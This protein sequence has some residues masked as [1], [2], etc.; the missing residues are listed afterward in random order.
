MRGL[1]LRGGPTWSAGRGGTPRGGTA[2][3][4]IGGQRPLHGVRSGWSGATVGARRS[5]RRALRVGGNVVE[6]LLL[7]VLL[8]VLLAALAVQFLWSGFTYGPLARRAL[9]LVSLPAGAVWA[10]VAALSP[11]RALVLRV[12][13]GLAAGAAAFLALAVAVVLR[14]RER[15]LAALVG[16]LAGL[17]RHVVEQRREVERLFWQLDGAARARASGPPPPQ[18]PVEGSE[19]AMAVRAWQ[20]GAGPREARVRAARIAE[21]RHEFR[22]CSRDDLAARARVLEAAR[23]DAPPEQRAIL[24]ARLALLWQVFEERL[25]KI[26]ADGDGPEVR[27][28]W[29]RARRELARLQEE[30]S[31]M[32]RQ[33][34]A[35]AQRRLPL[36]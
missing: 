2:C 5:F 29:E 11:W 25:P 21:W 15:K 6:Y 3:A 4:D 33:R 12:A 24:E 8:L 23:D 20:N 17:R 36:D 19:L 27:G 9:A 7:P 34:S 10:T 13:G 22:H 14:L 16:D 28:R 26:G 32:R 18:P 1:R 31:A 35:L 30:L